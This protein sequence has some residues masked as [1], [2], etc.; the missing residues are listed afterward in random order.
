MPHK[1]EKLEIKRVNYIFPKLFRLVLYIVLLVIGLFNIFVGQISPA[2]VKKMHNLFTQKF[3]FCEALFVNW[4]LNIQNLPLSLVWTLFQ[5]IIL[6]VIV[7]AKLR[8]WALQ[9]QRATKQ[10]TGHI[11]SSW[12]TFH[13]GILILYLDWELSLAFEKS[14]TNLTQGNSLE[15]DI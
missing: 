7:L 3:P 8:T 10:C 5:V 6:L 2:F 15:R 12:S 11:S 13:G 9:L 1:M 14:C 4:N